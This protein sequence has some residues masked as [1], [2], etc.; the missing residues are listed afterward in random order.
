[1]LWQLKERIADD[2]GLASMLKGIVADGGCSAVWKRFTR[3][4]GRSE[5]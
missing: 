1:M 3:A 4:K 2:S 5:T